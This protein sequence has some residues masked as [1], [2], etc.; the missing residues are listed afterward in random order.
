LPIADRFIPTKQEGEPDGQLCDRTRSSTSLGGLIGRATFESDLTP[1]REL[2]VWDE[3]IHIGQNCVKENGWYSIE[4]EKVA[5]G[6][7]VSQIDSRE[8]S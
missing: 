8:L 4:S 3:L 7:P 5:L 1:F 6:T 2:L